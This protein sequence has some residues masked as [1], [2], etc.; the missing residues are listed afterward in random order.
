[1]PSPTFILTMPKGHVSP[2]RTKADCQALAASFDPATAPRDQQL[3][4]AACVPVLHPK[5]ATP[6][7]PN[8]NPGLQAVAVMIIVGFVVLLAVLALEK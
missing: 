4:Y 5:P 1:M 7:N 3:K 8:D 2:G 6:V